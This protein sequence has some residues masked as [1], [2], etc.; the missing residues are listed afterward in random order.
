MAI[1]KEMMTT[2]K[3]GLVKKLIKFLKQERI[4]I[5]KSKKFKLY[6]IM[7]KIMNKAKF[8]IMVINRT[9]SIMVNKILVQDNGNEKKKLRRVF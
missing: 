1:S 4:I 6:K 7:D 8:I 9:V 3:N 2:M 5:I